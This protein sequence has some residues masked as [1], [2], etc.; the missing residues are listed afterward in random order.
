MSTHLFLI[1]CCGYLLEDASNEYP[2][3]TFLWRIGEDYSR[4]I[5]K[6][7]SLT[8]PLIASHNSNEYPH[9]MEFEFEILLNNTSNPVG[10]LC[11]LPEKGRE[12]QKNSR[13]FQEKETEKSVGKTECPPTNS[14]IIFLITPQKF[15]LL[16]LISSISL[17][18]F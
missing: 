11:H 2:Q 13:K 15:T 18:H 9:F 12:G 16:L 8:S 1:I 10:Y 5:V 14:R 4:I 6:Y 17:R 3:S 7:S